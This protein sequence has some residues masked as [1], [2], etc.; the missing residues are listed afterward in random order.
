MLEPWP[1]EVIRDQTPRA[2][3]WGLREFQRSGFSDIHIYVIRCGDTDYRKIGQTMD[4]AR[5][6]KGLQGSNPHP[7]TLE[8]S[9]EVPGFMATAIEQAIHRDLAAERHIYEWFKVGRARARAALIR[10]ERRGW[11]CHDARLQAQAA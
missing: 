10:W 4:L 9:V 2:P 7:L 1:L 5:R 6:L 8:F 3:F 11:E